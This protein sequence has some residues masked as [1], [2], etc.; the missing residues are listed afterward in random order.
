VFKIAKWWDT[1][2]TWQLC[3][4]AIIQVLVEARLMRNLSMVRKPPRSNARGV[5]VRAAQG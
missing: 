2:K 5:Q 4:D 3:S 1:I